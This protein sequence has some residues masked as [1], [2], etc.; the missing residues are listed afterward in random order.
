[1]TPPELADLGPGR[2]TGTFVRA[3]GFTSLLAIPTYESLLEFPRRAAESVSAATSGQAR[4]AYPCPCGPPPHP[5]S[6][7]QGRGRTE[8]NRPH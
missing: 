8:W 6:H 2:T 4:Q 7:H 3:F 1:M 5:R